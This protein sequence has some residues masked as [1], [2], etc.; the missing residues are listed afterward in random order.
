MSGC[1]RKSD[2]LFGDFIP[3]PHLQYNVSGKYPLLYYNTAWGVQSVPPL[4][5]EQLLPVESTVK[6]YEQTLGINVWFLD[7]TANNTD[8]DGNQYVNISVFFVPS[9]TTMRLWSGQ[10]VDISF[11]TLSG[12]LSPLTEE[13]NT[14]KKQYWKVVDNQKTM[15]DLTYAYAFP[16]YIDEPITPALLLEIVDAVK[17]N[18]DVDEEGYVC[19]ISKESDGTYSVLTTK[20][21]GFLNLSG[22]RYL[23]KKRSGVMRVIGKCEYSS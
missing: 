21:R 17:V 5:D 2:V 4:S 23:L 12:H 19:Y 18:L 15:N 3:G 16:I 14:V 13:A 6:I 11:T 7:V 1:S 22:V 10:Y 9:N 20:T 8:K